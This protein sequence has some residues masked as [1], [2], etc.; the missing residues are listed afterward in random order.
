MIKLSN[1]IKE[2]KE[3]LQK[4]CILFIGAP[5]SG[6]TTFIKTDLKKYFPQIKVTSIENVDNKLKSLQFNDA[7]KDYE[8]WKNIKTEKDLNDFIEKK[9]FIDNQNEKRVLNIKL[10][11]DAPMAFK[12][13]WNKFYKEFYASD[14]TNRAIAK[15]LSIDDFQDKTIKGSNFL[16]IDTSAGNYNICA[17]KIEDAKNE[18]YNI[19]IIILKIGIDIA[20][21]RDEYRGK[22]FGRKV[23]ENAV[24]EYVEKI[25]NTL[26][27]FI[28]NRKKYNVN[29]IL[30]FKWIATGDSI[31][32]GYY[33]LDKNITYKNNLILN[34]LIIKKEK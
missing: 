27:Y 7:K 29:R 6:K 32:D 3:D 18:G 21:K 17:K 12:D 8:E 30:I 5:G 13:Y 33:K 15:K 28:E 14:F 9:S 24:R 10:F 26:N 31:F 16:I 11:I 4:Q 2:F 20:I 1:I 23:G 34:N 19:N 25:E 22:M